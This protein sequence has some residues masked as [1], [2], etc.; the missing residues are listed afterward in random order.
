[1]VTTPGGCTFAGSVG[2]AAFR[3]TFTRPGAGIRDDGQGRYVSGQTV[4][5]PHSPMRVLRVYPYFPLAGE[6]RRTAGGGSDP[7]G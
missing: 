1:M 5:W 3:F 7:P 2:G 6:R 4:S